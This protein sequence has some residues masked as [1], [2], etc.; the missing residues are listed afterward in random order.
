MPRFDCHALSHLSLKFE[1][2][3][4]RREAQGWSFPT[5]LNALFCPRHF[6]LISV[7]LHFLE[8]RSV[9]NSLE[10][11]GRCPT[12]VISHQLSPFKKHALPLLYPDILYGSCQG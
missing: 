1:L 5:S 2:I 3:G 4:L 10:D 12:S 6:P 11:I 9:R 8:V 7:P